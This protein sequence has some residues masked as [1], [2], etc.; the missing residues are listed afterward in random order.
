MHTSTS[1]WL[2]MQAI[3]FLGCCYSVLVRTCL[4]NPILNAALLLVWK[5]FFI[6]RLHYYPDMYLVGVHFFLIRL[7][8]S[9]R[10]NFHR[11]PPYLPYTHTSRPL[12]PVKSRIMGSSLDSAD[13]TR[14]F[15]KHWQPNL[16]VFFYL[17]Y[18]CGGWG[19]SGRGFFNIEIGIITLS[20]NT[21]SVYL[22]DFFMLPVAYTYNVLCRSYILST[23]AKF[24]S[25]PDRTL[26]AMSITNFVGKHVMGRVI[27]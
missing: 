3:F 19:G 6:L 17:P 16:V 11:R 27:I 25:F 22:I 18:F 21:V 8:M 13:P 15:N 12:D 1:L 20:T 5:V 24:L 26:K 10:F 23:T 9:P 7:S 14:Y 4:T 2:H